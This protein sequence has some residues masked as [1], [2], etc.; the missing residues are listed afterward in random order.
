MKWSE[1]PFTNIIG[2]KSLRIKPEGFEFEIISS[3]HGVR[4]YGESP[5]F[6][7]HEAL[8]ELAKNIAKAVKFYEYLFKEK[9][10]LKAKVEKP[11][12]LITG[13]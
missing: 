9:N 12:K 5:W 1:I 4:L 11:K 6:A 7:D 8:N 10:G 13:E 2:E 3:L